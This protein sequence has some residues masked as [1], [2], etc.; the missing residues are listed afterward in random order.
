MLSERIEYTVRPNLWYTSDG[1]PLHGV[2][3]GPIVAIE[4]YQH[5]WPQ[6]TFIKA[7]RYTR[8][9]GLI[10]VIQGKC[11]QSILSICV[12]AFVLPAGPMQRSAGWNMWY[13]D[14]TTA[15]RAVSTLENS[16]RREHI[17]TASLIQQRVIFW[18]GLANAYLHE[19]C[20]CPCEK[21]L[22]GFEVVGLCQCIQLLRVYEHQPDSGVSFYGFT[23]WS[24]LSP[25]LRD[26]SPSVHTFTRNVNTF[27]N[28]VSN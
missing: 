21:C 28:S 4:W 16:I 6:M 15:I 18:R 1:R 26:F 14:K 10:K 17:Y 27:P 25:A 23:V 22:R 12:Q 11:R 24:S 20:M 8:S 13:S 5:Q 7:F 3:V 2:E 19:L 9:G